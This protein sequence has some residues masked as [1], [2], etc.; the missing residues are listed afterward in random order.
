MI[1]GKRPR[2]D[3]VVQVLSQNTDAF[4][5]GGGYS[6]DN[7]FRVKQEDAVQ[8]NP[9]IKPV[10]EAQGRTFTNTADNRGLNAK[11][12]YR[13]SVRISGS[14]VADA[15]SELSTPP[16]PSG[17]DSSRSARPSSSTYERHGSYRGLCCLWRCGYYLTLTPDFGP[18]ICIDVG[19]RGSRESSHDRKGER[20]RSRDRETRRPRTQRE[21]LRDRID[22]RGRDHDRRDRDR[23]R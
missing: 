6:A 20:S 14:D 18:H 12:G 10:Q 11:S 3:S 15:K 7:S 1:L 23:N 5:F 13:P 8:D 9:P 22:N 4:D 2:D 17:H 19:E 21:D 16:R